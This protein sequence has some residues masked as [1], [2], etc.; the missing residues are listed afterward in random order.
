[1]CGIRTCE[2]TFTSR[3]L[4]E[5]CPDEEMLRYDDPKDVGTSEFD[6]SGYFDCWDSEG[7]EHWVYNLENGTTQE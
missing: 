7:N 6:S 5:A 1:M 3:N 4:A 2:L